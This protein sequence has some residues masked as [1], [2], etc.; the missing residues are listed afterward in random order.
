MSE[1]V[2]DTVSTKKRVDQTLVK[3]GGWSGV[4]CNKYERNEGYIEAGLQSTRHAAKCPYCGRR[5]APPSRHAPAVAFG[6][7]RASNPTAH[8]SFMAI[9]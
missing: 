2:I 5:I 4:R 1:R 8:L 9:G 7:F 6:P 3:I